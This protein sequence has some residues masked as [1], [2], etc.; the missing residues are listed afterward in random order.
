MLIGIIFGAII[1]F[2]FFAYLF[3]AGFFKRGNA[4]QY[5]V[6]QTEELNSSPISGKTIL[7]LGSSVTKGF[8]ARGESFVDYIQKRNQCVCIKEAVSGTTLLNSGST[9][10]IPRM[11]KLKTNK[12]DAF[13]C[14][15]STN[16]RVYK[17]RLGN[18]S[19]S[20]N[21]DD[22]D[23]TTTT[24]AIEF[25]ISFA[26]ETWKCP[27]VFYT[28]PYFK[29]DRYKAMVD[30]LLEMKDKWGID[31]IDLCYN[32]EI[33]R[34]PDQDHRLYMMMDHIHPVRAGYKLW[35]TPVFEKVLYHLLGQK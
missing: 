3:L 7:F 10:Y 35:L 8:S 33:N 20:T 6:A 1:V 5:S 12:V 26:K 18:I 24:G 11:L 21:R 9:S 23:I 31:M 4:S 19:Q 2:V 22:F 27:V 28:N 34:I 13:V 29:N 15:L 32:E 25:I 14:Q 16:D 17:T 30:R